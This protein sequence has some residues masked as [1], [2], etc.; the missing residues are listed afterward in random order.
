M[1][2]PESTA[3]HALQ[4]G[5]TNAINALIVAAACAGT[6]MNTITEEVQQIADNLKE[7]REREQS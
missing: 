5:L 2:S 6:D 7:E 4:W 1:M 3:R